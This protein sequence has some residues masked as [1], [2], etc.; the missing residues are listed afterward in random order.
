MSWLEKTPWLSLL[1]LCLTY[2]V[3]GWSISS[4]VDSWSDSILETAQNIDLLIEKELI[5][6]T[7]HLLALAVIVLISLFL[8]TP[9]ALI[10]F[11]FQESIDSDFKA[12]IALF[13]WSFIAVI[14]FCFWNYFADLMVMISAGILVKLDLQKLGCK[15]WQVFLIIILGASLSFFFGVMSFAM[16]RNF[17]IGQY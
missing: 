4:S 10:T 15:S 7:I 17:T 5:A 9:V 14:I 2:A 12:S 16:K 1:I 8:T 13:L 3:F 11:V 6:I